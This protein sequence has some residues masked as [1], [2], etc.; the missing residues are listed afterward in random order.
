MP[1][2]EVVEDNIEEVDKEV[3]MGEVPFSGVLVAEQALVPPAA[4]L[5]VAGIWT[6]GPSNQVDGQGPAVSLRAR[7][8]APTVYAE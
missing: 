4:L 6:G 3:D 7:G 8:K 5:A 1:M 2:E